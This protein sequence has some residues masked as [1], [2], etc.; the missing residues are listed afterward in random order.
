MEVSIWDSQKPSTSY[1]AS[2]APTLIMLIASVLG[3]LLIL[4]YHIL[5]LI[6][7]IVANTPYWLEMILFTPLYLLGAGSIYAIIIFSIISLYFSIVIILF[8]IVLVL[9]KKIKS[10]IMLPILVLNISF[11]FF[12]QELLSSI[13]FGITLI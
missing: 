1:K 12:G 6:G 3:W 9:L 2:N 13:S 11:I 4:G 8:S 7:P 5:L 10:W